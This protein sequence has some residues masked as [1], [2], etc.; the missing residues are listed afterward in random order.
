MSTA[1]ILGGARCVWDDF[2]AAVEIGEFDGVVACNDVGAVWPGPLDAWVSLHPRKFGPWA[3]RRA[4]LGLPLCERLIGHLESRNDAAPVTERLEFRFPGQ[5]APG[6]SGLFAAKV[7]LI[8]L[9]FDR[10]VLAGV[11][12]TADEGNIARDRPWQD[13]NIYWRGWRE[14]LPQIRDRL[15]SMSGWTAE[16]LGRPDADWLTALGRGDPTADTR[17]PPRGPR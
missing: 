16:L 3:K 12:M 4:D 13:A 9:G 17:A 14:A 1:L 6:S 2:K 7:A 8:D 10:A 11:P 15:R 5:Q